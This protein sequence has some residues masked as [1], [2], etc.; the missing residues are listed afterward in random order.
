MHNRYDTIAVKAEMTADGWI[1]DKPVITRAGIFKY[2]SNGKTVREYRPAE[3]VFKE[4]SLVTLSGV[5]ITDGHHGML[6]ATSDLGNVIGTV[7][8]PGARSND[9]VVADIVIHNV[10]KLGAKRELSLGYRCDIDDTPG[11]FNGEQYDVIQKNIRYNHLAV[12]H[13][14]RAGNA[15]I[16]LDSNSAASFD[17]ENDMPE[18]PKIRL[19]NIEYSASQEVINHIGKLEKDNGAL[20]KMVNTVTGE[21]DTFKSTLAEAEKKHKDALASERQRAKVRVGLETIAKQYNLE[22]KEDASDRDLMEATIKKLGHDLKFDGKSD[23]YVQSAY[24]LAVE[25]AV[26]PGSNIRQKEV[27]NNKRQDNAGGGNSKDA[28]ER[29]LARIRGEKPSTGKEAA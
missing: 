26:K 17:V 12:V 9:N 20:Q 16:R 23:D 13:R 6:A 10:S 19:D 5:P 2:S 29:M 14:G 11:V 8:T 24:D 4:D 15:R 25:K 7:M 1:R 22:F 21:R 18:L 27:L 3:E 28:R